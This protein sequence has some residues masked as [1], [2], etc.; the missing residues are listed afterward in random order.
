MENRRDGNTRERRERRV[1][2]ERRRSLALR[3]LVAC[4]LAQ[5]VRA[6]LMREGE[7][8]D[9]LRAWHEDAVDGL[10]MVAQVLAEVAAQLEGGAV[11]GEK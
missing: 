9:V 4:N 6:Q 3:A 10:G 7:C 2:R 1:R 11:N 8:S 5:A